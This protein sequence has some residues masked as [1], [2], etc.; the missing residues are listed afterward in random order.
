MI[1]CNGKKALNTFKPA[2]RLIVKIKIH[3]KQGIRYLSEKIKTSFN[4]KT[5]LMTNNKTIFCFILIMLLSGCQLLDPR[6]GTVHT[7][8]ILKKEG[9]EAALRGVNWLISKKDSIPANAAL[10]NFKKIYKTTNDKRLAKKILRVIKEKKK[11]IARINTSIDIKNKKHLNW[12]EL[13]PIVEELLRR[14]C[15]GEEYMTDAEKIRGLLSSNW[16]DIF[17]KKMLLSQKLVAAYLLGE[18][19]ACT[20]EFYASVTKR[21]RSRS[22]VLDKPSGYGYF[23]YLYALTHIVFTESDYYGHYLNS[24]KFEPEINGLNKAINRFSSY[25]EIS[26]NIADILSEIL[27][28]FKLLQIKPDQRTDRTYQRLIKRQNPDGS[29]GGE[30]ETLNARIHHTLVATLALLEF[31]PAFR[32]KKI[33]CPSN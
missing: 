22:K 7:E 6:M 8:T 23:F 29:W 21:I 4:L 32:G 2:V 31:S 1:Y 5:Y 12:F 19:G 11:S 17:T 15:A 10:S 14:K 18:L 13:R 27:I 9:R 26:D 24:E 3:P 30:K 25:P 33:Y 20:D 16:N 28:C